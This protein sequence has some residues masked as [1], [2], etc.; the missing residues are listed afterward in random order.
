M[1]V[2]CIVVLSCLVFIVVVDFCVDIRF[3]Y[4]DYEEAAECR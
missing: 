1:K 4:D 3:V 2:G